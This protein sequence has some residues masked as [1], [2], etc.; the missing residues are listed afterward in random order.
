MEARD[1]LTRVTSEVLGDH[2]SPRSP[3]AIGNRIY[4]AFVDG[5]PLVYDF[6][7]A[8]HPSHPAK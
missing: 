7:C 8:A 6:Y 2:D 4:Q 3:L 5:W 1:Y